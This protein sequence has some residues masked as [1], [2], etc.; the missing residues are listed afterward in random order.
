LTNRNNIF[1]QQLRSAG[2]YPTVDAPVFSQQGGQVPAG[3]DLTI[4]A[5]TGTIWYTLDGSDPRMIGGGINPS[6]IA[7]T[8]AAVDIPLTSTVRARALSGGQWSALNEA[9]FV[10]PATLRIT[11]VHYNPAAYPGVADRQ[12]MEFIEIANVGGQSASLNGYQ[13]SGFADT[14]YTFDSGI[15]LA[16]GAR[17]IVARNPDVFSFVY[18]AGHNVAPVGYS[19]MNLSN[20]G[21]RVTLI[22]PFGTVVQDFTYA[23]ISPWPS[24]ADGNGPSLELI[25]PLGDATDP[26]NWRA[27]QYTGGSPGASGV[28]GDFDGNNVVND[29]DY[30]S[31]RGSFGLIVARG[32][33]ADGNRDGVIDTADYV[34]WRKQNL[35]SETA[36][37][38]ATASS[39]VPQTTEDNVGIGDEPLARP[40]GP[41]SIDLALAAFSSAR[42]TA[43]PPARSRWRPATAMLES[44]DELLLLATKQDGS[45]ADLKTHVLTEEE[46]RFSDLEWHERRE[47]FLDLGGEFFAG[48]VRN[49]RAELDVAERDLAVIAL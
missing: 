48:V 2:L 5:S 33:G 28:P 37:T 30:A 29:A 41:E 8:G 38:I 45:P 11:E 4:S 18:G 39:A 10:T 35:V 7:Y 27:S 24:A 9:T 17:I 22:D 49:D 44:R 23:D 46:S 16:A 47:L 15:E 43:R 34:F 19:P 20:G 21:E 1:L 32:T 42:S 26:A 40:I 3:Y 25:N 12:D 36:T 31:W 6:A 13:I 14:P